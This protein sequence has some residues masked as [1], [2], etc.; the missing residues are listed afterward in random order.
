ME[1]GFSPLSLFLF[2]LVMLIPILFA[3]ILGVVHAKLLVN[4][5]LVVQL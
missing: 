3:F 5:C 1:M 2:L 4:Y